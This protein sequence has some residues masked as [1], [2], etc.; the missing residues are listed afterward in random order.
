MLKKLVIEIVKDKQIPFFVQ[1][2]KKLQYFSQHEG[3]TV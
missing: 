3:V 2:F 1:N